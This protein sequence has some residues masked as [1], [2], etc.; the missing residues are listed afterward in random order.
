MLYLWFSIAWKVQSLWLTIEI[1]TGY[2]H[3]VRA[4]SAFI[5]LYAKKR[6]KTKKRFSEMKRDG[7]FVEG[8]WCVIILWQ[9][10]L[11]NTFTPMFIHKNYIFVPSL[12]LLFFSKAFSRFPCKMI[13]DKRCDRGTLSGGSLICPRVPD[14]SLT[15]RRGFCSLNY[16]NNEVKSVFSSVYS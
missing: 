1:R 6:L 12:Y 16:R 5:D 2:I 11:S 7:M 14:P 8:L 15:N 13:A 3:S 10:Q 4:F 9:I